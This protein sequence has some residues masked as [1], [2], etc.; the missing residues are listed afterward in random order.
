[1]R[2]ARSRA[3]GNAARV[4]TAINALNERTQGKP[5]VPDETAAY[6]A[7]AATLAQHRVDGLVQVPVTPDVYEPVKRRYGTRPATTVHSERMRVRAASEEA[8][9]A[10]AVRRLGWRVSATKHTTAE[11]ALAQ[12]VAA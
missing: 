6:Q 1:V 5:R 12:G 8:P 3:C 9:L 7:A 10:H 2:R 11:V 4:V